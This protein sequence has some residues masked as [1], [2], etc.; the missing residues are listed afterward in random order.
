MEVTRSVL[1]LLGSISNAFCISLSVCILNLFKFPFCCEEQVQIKKIPLWSIR[2]VPHVAITP[3]NYDGWYC[4]SNVPPTQVVLLHVWCC[5][6]YLF[7]SRNKKDF[8]LYFFPPSEDIFLLFRFKSKGILQLQYQ[9]S[10]TRANI[11]IVYKICKIWGEFH[12]KRKREALMG[13]M[14]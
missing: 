2:L 4:C 9:Y 10:R 12:L 14:W 8:P 3:T 5:I 1:F 7:L 13:F 11:S 6:F